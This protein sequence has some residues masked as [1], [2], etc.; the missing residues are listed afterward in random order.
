M[1]TQFKV[2]ERN[3]PRVD[4]HDKVT[5]RATY[6]SDVYLPGMLACKLLPSTRNHARIVRLDTSKA[7]SHPGVRCVITGT[8]FPDI[9]Y[10]SGALRD[11]YVMPRE[12]VNFIGEPIAAVAADD[13]AT[14]QEAIELIEVAYEDMP[15]V[16]NPLS[17]MG[18]DA[19][20]VHPELEEY[21]GYGFALGHNVST[22]LD[23]DRGDVDQA[24]SDAD[25]VVEDVYRSQGINQGFLEPMACVADV[26]AN[27]RLV[28]RLR[29]YPG[30]LSDP[31]R[32]GG[33]ARNPGVADPRGS[34]GAWRRF[35]SQAAAGVRGFPRP[36]GN[37]NGTTREV[38][39]HPRGSV[40]HE[41]PAP[42]RN[43]LHPIRSDARRHHRGPRSLYDLRRGS[44]PWR[45]PQLGHRS[46]HRGPTTCPTSGCVPTAC[47]PTR[48]TSVRTG[49][50]VS[51][52]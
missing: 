14:A 4:A 50:R 36:P 37:E 9:R 18:S 20:T 13:E 16:V 51:P 1:T 2:L 35:R 41:R 34:Y 30:P 8:D 12:V 6:A 40:H 48:S 38:G 19:A 7:E 44:L 11:R 47:T 21:E 28:V 27:G 45:R 22:L 24:F 15:A 10:G 29:F 52:T 3:H 43:Q 31:G 33:C 17:A 25:V 46:R 42:P 23:A 5:G 26:E 49:L 39:E 32:A